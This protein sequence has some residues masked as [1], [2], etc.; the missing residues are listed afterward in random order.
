[1][2]GLCINL[3]P[4]TE[5]AFV[6]VFQLLFIESSAQYRDF[7]KYDYEWKEAFEEDIVQSEEFRDSDVTI[8]DELR[9]FKVYNVQERFINIYFERRFR[10]RVNTT[11][12]AVSI[13]QLTLPEPFDPLLD[14]SDTPLEERPENC[15]PNVFNVRVV[16]C[17][18]RKRADGEE[19]QEVSTPVSY[20]NENVRYFYQL[21]S[22]FVYRF[23]LPG[24]RAGDEVEVHYK[25]EI[26]Y[27]VN[28]VYFDAM[29]AFFHGKYPRQHT[30]YELEL[31]NLLI[32][33]LRG[34]SPHKTRT[35]KGKEVF[36]WEF[37]NL[38]GSMDEVNA[39]PYEELPHFILNVKKN[40]ERFN[41]R[42]YLSNDLLRAPYWRKV[43]QLRQEDALF[44]Y[45]RSRRDWMM[46]DEQARKV[47]Q[48]ISDQS[49]N[50]PDSL[51]R[52]K[53]AQI[54]TT[55]ATDF[56]YRDDRAWY[57]NEDLGLMKMGDNV[58][59]RSLR[60]IMRHTLYPRIF[61]RLNLGY[62]THYMVDK[63]LA[64][65]SR[66]FLTN[67]AF[68]DYLYK[69]EDRG[70]VSFM[71]PKRSDFGWLVNEFPFYWQG[72][73]S[74]ETTLNRIFSS[75]LYDPV[76]AKL[77]EYSSRVNYRNTRAIIEVDSEDLSIDGS[78][79][80]ELSGQYSTLTR[81]LY[82]HGSVDS[83][84][85]Q[86]YAKLFLNS[87]TSSE[88]GLEPTSFEKTYPFK[89]NFRLSLEGEIAGAIRG[90]TLYLPLKDWFNVIFPEL[91]QLQ[92]RS[93]AYYPDY[94]GEDVYT[95]R[96]KMD[97]PVELL[98]SLGIDAR[99]EG[100]HFSV[101][102]EISQRSANV[103][104]IKLVHRTKSE[105]VPLEDFQEVKKTA[106]ALEEIDSHVLKIRLAEL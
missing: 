21:D 85:S 23:N 6:L 97:K 84:I 81:S 36:S 65:I 48:F 42:F 61:F 55:I 92:K 14:C 35:R 70:G 44:Y 41:Y 37:N 29:R 34:S 38:P 4:I 5:L 31:P 74:M 25:L 20:L 103:V 101:E 7:L 28:W 50:I 59:D 54:H 100:G 83:T 76:I 62:N 91:E 26:P 58:E 39:H 105:R 104:E 13:S 3:I 33:D 73:T 45:L 78:A 46:M 30:R 71:H 69:L 1:M 57:L 24:I 66:D 47:R 15:F 67:L 94:A 95:V 96:L 89:T 32:S 72:S 63:R 18:A 102:T 11:D 40:D 93:L 86:D 51:P 87:V 22:S 27:D 88:N 79:R 56:N 52:K 90:D 80:I 10:A 98:S 60:S 49:R 17:E 8:L 106:R 68:N 19:W 77:P 2:K 12:G 99:F 43:L 82:S 53:A 75:N 64:S 9:K 16:F